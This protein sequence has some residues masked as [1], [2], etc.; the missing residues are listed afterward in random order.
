MASRHPTPLDNATQQQEDQPG[1]ADAFW[2]EDAA[3][4][5]KI[6]EDT[7]ATN[8]CM[9]VDQPGDTGPCIV[10]GKQSN[11]HALFARAY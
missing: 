7:K 10:C 4:E 2:C 9:P 3:C 6:K 1:R 8:R 5:N 11:V